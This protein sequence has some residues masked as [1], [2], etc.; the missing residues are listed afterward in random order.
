MNIVVGFINIPPVNASHDRRLVIE[1]HSETAPSLRLTKP[2]PALQ[3]WADSLNYDSL[4]TTDHGHIPFPVILIKEADR[5]KAEVSE[6]KSLQ[7]TK[8]T[9]FTSTA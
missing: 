2:F 9:G 7:V 3:E 4:D 6:P 5:W 8:L 1:S